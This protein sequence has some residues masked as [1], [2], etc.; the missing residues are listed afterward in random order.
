MVHP[1]SSASGIS[2]APSK[3]SPTTPKDALTAKVENL[4]SAINGN[5]RFLEADLGA[6]RV[7]I[8]DKNT[9]EYTLIQ[10]ALPIKNVA[11]SGGGARGVI[12]P[13]VFKA[14]EEHITSSGATF[15]QQLDDISGSS[16]GAISS[17][18]FAAGMP[19]DKL[20][21]EL[22]KTSFI[23]LLGKGYG[24]IKFD[25]KPLEEFLR[26]HMLLSVRENLKQIF[27]TDDLSKVTRE[28]VAEKLS[29]SRS[30]GDAATLNA[31]ME[32]I[33]KV[34]S[35]EGKPCRIT[36][37]MLRN[38]HYL[39]PNIFK[40]LTVT[41]TCRDTGELCYFDADRTPHLEVAKGC[42][43]S[44]SLPVI[45]TD[46]KI[47]RKFLSP[48]YD[49]LLPGQDDIAFVDG[50]YCDN[51]PT[52]VL[53]DK[54]NSANGKG[55]Y[56]QNLQT[57]ALVFDQ[58]KRKEHEQSPLFDVKI[59]PNALFNPNN[60]LEQ[61]IRD[62]MSTL[63]GRINA[64]E[65]NT[66]VTARGFEDIRIKYTQRNIPLLMPILAIDFWKAKKHEKKYIQRGYDQ[67]MEYL[68]IHDGE[69]LYRKFESLNAM[70]PY[71]TGLTSDAKTIA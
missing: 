11:I 63:V 69:L 46:V 23:S 42:R 1:V 51:I 10:P 26:K 54:Q 43:A 62:R 32:I 64:Q 53:E 24:P 4:R 18:L 40:D 61:L 12:L 57:L 48:G 66:V 47:H 50:G 71:L 52:A 29:C 36:F 35:K 16:I 34:D 8:W 58:S 9:G 14:F 6:G 21:D 17:S 28:Q 55:D 30:Q 31:I 70:K 27:F 33:A 20:I 68:K 3:A 56:G 15:R 59:A 25:G 39:E 7:V 19:A 41:A 65:K 60:L 37:S 45:L 5:E 44:G 67:A 38:L 49:N 13:G 22:S 2:P